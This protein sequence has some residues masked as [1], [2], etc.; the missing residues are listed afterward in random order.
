LNRPTDSGA[1]VFPN[2]HILSVPNCSQ[3][4]PWMEKNSSR[5]R[6]EP[7]ER[8]SEQARATS[9]QAEP[10]TSLRPNEQPPKKAPDWT[11]DPRA[12]PLP[13]GPSRQDRLLHETPPTTTV[14]LW[15]RSPRPPAEPFTKDSVLPRPRSTL[16]RMGAS[17]P[18]AC[19][20]TAV[21]QVC[22]HTTILQAGIL[23][24]VAYPFSRGS[25]QHRDITWVS[26]VAGKF[27]TSLATREAQFRTSWWLR[28]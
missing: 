8:S 13:S 15:A 23:E 21:R 11:P 12:T 3:I 20:Y 1:K 18:G 22:V 28:Q 19:V 5:R 26:N 27:F 6:A 17:S 7:W 24:W 2:P 10:V 16:A 4:I 25:S 9:A 14:S